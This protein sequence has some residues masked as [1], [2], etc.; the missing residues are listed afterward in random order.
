MGFAMLGIVSFYALIGEQ[1]IDGRALFKIFCPRYLQI[2]SV[3]V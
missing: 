1:I 2:S 3:G